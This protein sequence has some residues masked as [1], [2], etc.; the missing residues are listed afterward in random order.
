MD[1]TS[2]RFNQSHVFRYRPDLFV[3]QCVK[4]VELITDVYIYIYILL[5]HLQI[6]TNFS[7]F[8]M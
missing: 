4:F 7:N 6:S 1:S 8:K 2:G 3:A 5:S